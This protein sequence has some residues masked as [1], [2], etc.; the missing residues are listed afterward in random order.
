MVI[1]G[2]LD[3]LRSHVERATED[4]SES[5]GGVKEAGKAKIGH[6]DVHVLIIIRLQQNVLWLDIPIILN[7]T[8]RYL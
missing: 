6:F 8:E 1:S 3:N 4:V 5:H 7:C 2:F